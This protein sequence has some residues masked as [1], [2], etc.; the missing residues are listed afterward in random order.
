MSL[1]YPLVVWPSN[2]KGVEKEGVLSDGGSGE[3][4]DSWELTGGTRH[5]E[6]SERTSQAAH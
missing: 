3:N 4:R 1:A 6:I 5:A 2:S